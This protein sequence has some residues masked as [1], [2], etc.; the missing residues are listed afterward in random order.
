MKQTWNG[1]RNAKRNEKA[2]RKPEVG[3]SYLI[4]A[5]KPDPTKVLFQRLHLSNKSKNQFF[6]AEP[7]LSY[8]LISYLKDGSSR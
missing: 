8:L 6:Q 4:D 3:E 1:W 5:L 7:F 2:D